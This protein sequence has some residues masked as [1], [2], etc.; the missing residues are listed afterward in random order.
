MDVGPAH[1]LRSPLVFQV[2][3]EPHFPHLERFPTRLGQNLHR[4]KTQMVGGP[5]ATSH[6]EEWKALKASG[7]LPSGCPMKFINE[8]T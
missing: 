7:W 1:L 2:G 5:K 4:S 8:N 6:K 3:A